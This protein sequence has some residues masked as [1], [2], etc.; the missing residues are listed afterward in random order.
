MAQTNISY[1]YIIFPNILAF[2][3]RL[4]IRTS[5]ISSLINTTVKQLNKT[6][7]HCLQM[8]SLI[9]T[10]RD[11]YVKNTTVN[12]AQRKNN[13]TISPHTSHIFV[14][15]TGNKPVLVKNTTPLYIDVQPFS[16]TYMQP[17]KLIIDW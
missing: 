2:Y 16:Y 5:C 1:K 12:S 17:D 4:F 14:T 13:I 10:L 3:S 15:Q 9:L 8:S 6:F 11:L 7:V